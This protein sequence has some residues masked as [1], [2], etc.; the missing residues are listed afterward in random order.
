[1]IATKEGLAVL[2]K[3]IF[4]NTIVYICI[5]SDATCE[6]EMAFQNINTLRSS[7]ASLRS[8]EDCGTYQVKM[9]LFQAVVWKQA[10]FYV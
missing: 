9:I 5:G 2:S 1:M 6:E 3:E 8:F 4:I 10:R 7:N